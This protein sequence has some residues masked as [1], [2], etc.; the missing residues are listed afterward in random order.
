[1]QYLLLIIACLFWG[2]SFVATRYALTAGGLG[3][4]TLLSGRF[5]IASLILILLLLIRGWR[6]LNGKDLLRLLAIGIIYPGLYFLFETTGLTRIPAF[7]ASI[8]IASIP[9]LT[10]I[11]A[12]VFLKERMGLRGWSGTFL[13]V[14]GVALVVLLA[15]REMPSTGQQAPTSA[16]GVLLTGGAAIM[17]AVYITLARYLTRSYQ[18]LTLTTAQSIIG[19]LLF[20]PM[21]SLELGRGQLNI[22]LWG[23]ISLG[24]LGIGVSVVAFLSFNKA[25]SVIEASKA[26]LFLNIIPVISFILGWLLLGERMNPGQG[27]GALVVIGGILLATWSPKNRTG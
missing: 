5:L 14:I 25:L 19:L 13:S 23:L 27:I 12:H 1:M 21:A 6:K 16:V 17:G 11:I 24:F 8:I 9:A 18:P 15:N 20:L 26:S 2:S 7:L 10:G 3:V 4:F 22:N